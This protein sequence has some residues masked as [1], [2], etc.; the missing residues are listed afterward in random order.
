MHMYE[1]FLNNEGDI[2]AIS[3]M[4]GHS[5]VMITKKVYAAV[6]PETLQRT[7]EYYLFDC[8][9]YGK[10]ELLDV[11]LQLLLQRQ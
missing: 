6:L 11:G 3:A 7:V 10:S 5:S 4:M 9:C 8:C 2:K 1:K